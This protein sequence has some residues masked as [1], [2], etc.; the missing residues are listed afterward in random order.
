MRG[1]GVADDET[2]GEIQR[3]DDIGR[4]RLSPRSIVA[5]VLAAL[6]VLLA[7]LNLEKVSVDLAV[8]SVHMPLILLI[9]LSGGIGF[10]VGWHFFRRRERRQRSQRDAD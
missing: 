6:L 3:A 4:K 1:T 9:A 8:R 5:I 2:S 10:L 7:V